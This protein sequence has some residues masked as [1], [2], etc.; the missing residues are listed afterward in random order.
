[1]SHGND[2]LDMVSRCPTP[3]VGLH[4]GRPALRGKGEAGMPLL[5]PTAL[6]LALGL[7]ERG[8]ILHRLGALGRLCDDGV[9]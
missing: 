4:G 2:D 6:L 8:G 5:R 7:L 3:G 1:M 9:P